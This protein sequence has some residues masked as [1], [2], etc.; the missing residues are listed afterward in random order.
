MALLIPIACIRR[1]KGCK[2]IVRVIDNSS[3]CFK[4]LL[5]WIGFNEM[6]EK[7]DKL[8]RMEQILRIDPPVELVF[9][10]EVSNC[11]FLKGIYVEKTCRHCEYC[12]CVC[13]CMM[14]KQI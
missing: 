14:N 3:M 8:D 13:L 6:P 12:V 1:E 9:K 7:F 10:G 4:L 11:M 5:S 2:S